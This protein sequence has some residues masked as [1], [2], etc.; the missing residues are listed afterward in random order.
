MTQPP[1]T[2]ICTQMWQANLNT[3]R[4]YRPREQGNVLLD[5]HVRQ[6]EKVTDY[7]THVSGI[8]PSDLRV[9]ASKCTSGNIVTLNR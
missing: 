8:R 6:K 9:S 7:R 5:V 4:A 2:L 1:D 3:E